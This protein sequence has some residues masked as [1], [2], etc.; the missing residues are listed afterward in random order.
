M[1]APRAAHDRGNE[2]RFAPSIAKLD[3]ELTIVPF[4]SGPR[5]Y[6][7]AEYRPRAQSAQF[8]IKPAPIAINEQQSQSISVKVADPAKSFTVTGNYLKNVSSVTADKDC[9]HTTV[10][11]DSTKTPD[12]KNLYV[13]VP[14]PPKPQLRL[15]ARRRSPANQ[16]TLR[17]SLTM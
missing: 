15:G 8:E 14:L 3:Q 17:N 12:D 13:L 1:N 6:F 16:V 5:Y 9:P 2:R 11:I 7:V 10:S 4:A